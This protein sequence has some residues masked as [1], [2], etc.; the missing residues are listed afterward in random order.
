MLNLGAVAANLFTSAGPNNLNRG[1]KNMGIGPQGRDRSLSTQSGFMMG[2][3]L[4][5]QADE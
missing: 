2:P 4:K 1:I 5:Q 3:S